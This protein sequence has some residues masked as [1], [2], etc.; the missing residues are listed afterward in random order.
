MA[1]VEE[2]DQVVRENDVD[3]KKLVDFVLPHQVV[4]A[5]RSKTQ[6]FRV[7]VSRARRVR[8]TT[9]SLPRRVS[10][11]CVSSGRPSHGLVTGDHCG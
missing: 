2:D 5:G 10:F 3:D 11:R 1:V 9:R 8:G 7:S 4:E 6:T